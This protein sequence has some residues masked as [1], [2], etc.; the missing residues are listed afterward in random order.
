MSLRP[1][2]FVVIVYFLYLAATAG[3]VQLPSTRRRLVA[4]E[5]IL[6]AA[7]AIWLSRFQAGWGSRIREW[8]PLAYILAGYWLPGR[9][10]SA[11]SV[12]VERSLAAFDLRW[13]AGA[14]VALVRQLPLVVLDLLEAAYLFCYPLLPIGFLCVQFLDDRIAVDR[15]WTAVILSAALCYG[16]LPWLPTRPPRNWMGDSIRLSRVRALNLWVLDRASVQLNTFPSGHVATSVA[17]ALAVTA[18]SPLA[19]LALGLAAF[20]ITVASVVGKYHYGADA[21]AGIVVACIAFA[22]SRF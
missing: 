5:A 1:W 12:P 6:V 3:L 4:A 15:F 20:G 19:G 7:V 10:V 11:P 2:E 14:D 17:A 16:T 22:L 21:L 18:S 8:A 9:L 13:L